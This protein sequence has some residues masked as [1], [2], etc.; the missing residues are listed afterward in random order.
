ML[1]DVAAINAAHGL[2]DALNNK[3]KRDEAKLNTVYQALYT[4]SPSD[5]ET[6]WALEYLKQTDKPWTL[7]HVLFCANEFLHV[8]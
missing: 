1:N 2:E 3:H 8:E 4:R 6:K 5:N 7:Y